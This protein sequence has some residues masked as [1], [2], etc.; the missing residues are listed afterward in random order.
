MKDFSLEYEKL[1]F[2]DPH[3]GKILKR[4]LTLACSKTGLN[5]TDKKILVEAMPQEKGCLI[6]LTLIPN[7]HRKIYRIKKERKNLC[8]V[9]DD[10]EGLISAAKAFSVN[11]IYPENSVYL[12]D[13]KYVVVLENIIENKEQLAKFREFSSKTLQGK[14]QT[15]RVKENGKLLVGK[16]GMEVI[17][18]YF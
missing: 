5:T 17:N 8:Y 11:N 2:E 15:A 13:N 6:L 1:S 14:I 9:F 4:L 12:W 18:K 10:T 16:N 7:I 3:S